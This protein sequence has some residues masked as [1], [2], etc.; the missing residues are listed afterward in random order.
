MLEE[1]GRETTFLLHPRNLAQTRL[2][3]GGLN[4]RM[5]RSSCMAGV[6]RDADAAAAAGDRRT[7][8][9]SAAYASSSAA[10][11]TCTCGAQRDGGQTRRKKAEWQQQQQ[12][13]ARAH[14]PCARSCRP[15]RLTSSSL[16]ATNTAAAAMSERSCSVIGRRIKK[17]CSRSM[18]VVA[19][20]RMRSA[21]N[22]RWHSART[23]AHAPRRARRSVGAHTP[24]ATKDGDARS[25]DGRQ[26]HAPACGKLDAYMEGSAAANYYA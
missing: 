26:R 12:K 2:G 24:P 14:P 7:P 15:L 18:A 1:S 6:F 20:T 16:A 25:E 17:R 23:T 13:S 10:G 21:S 3:R 9:V 4:L 19:G 5:S 8:V 11:R 22:R